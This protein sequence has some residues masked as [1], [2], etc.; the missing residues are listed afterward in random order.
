MFKSALNELLVCNGDQPPDLC[1]LQI[2]KMDD[3]HERGELKAE[4]ISNSRNEVDLRTKAR[5]KNIGSRVLNGGGA[6]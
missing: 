1:N 6:A 4:K 5:E 2:E 3:T